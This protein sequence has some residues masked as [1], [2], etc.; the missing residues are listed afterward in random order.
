MQ[1]QTLLLILP[2]L[3]AAAPISGPAPADELLRRGDASWP[4]F[5]SPKPVPGTQPKEVTCILPQAPAGGADAL[6][7][8]LDPKYC[9]KEPTGI[10]C[11]SD[12]TDDGGFTLLPI[13]LDPAPAQQKRD[14]TPVAVPIPKT[15][16]LAD[17]AKDLKLVPRLPSEVVRKGFTYGF[18]I[19]WKSVPVLDELALPADIKDTPNPGVPNP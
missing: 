9:T 19:G 7:S 1:P 15:L 8:K 18:K 5:C 3:C 12:G 11:H 16:V 10:T 13:D 6:L 4:D 2:L 17:A 14:V